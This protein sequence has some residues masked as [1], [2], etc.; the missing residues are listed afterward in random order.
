MDSQFTA[1]A[2][3]ISVAAFVVASV[4]LLYTCRGDRRKSGIDIRYR[5]AISSSVS[6]SERWVSEVVLQNAK[7]RAVSI[8]KMYLEVGHGLYIEIED[9]SRSPLILEA[10]GIHHQQ[11]DPIE[12]YVGGPYRCIDVLGDRKSRQR[13]V[14]IT[15]Q[16]RHFPKRRIKFDDPIY[17][18]IST[19]Y[20]ASVVH[21]IRL[22]YGGRSYGSEVMYIVT[23]KS[24]DGKE[25]VIPIYPRDYELKWFK[26]LGL[27]RQAME[28]K[29]ALEDCIR[30]QMDMGNLNCADV[31][32]FDP[33]PGRSRWYHEYER[34]GH[35][36]VRGWFQYNVLGRCWTMRERWRMHRDN[37][38]LRKNAEA[39]G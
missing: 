7:D 4:A 28:S 8:F 5:L 27:T 18:S 38:G 33:G 23:L 35:V 10:Y 14:L 12:F 11:Y 32:I 20:T 3:V 6:S 19:N 29:Q 17:D 25:E 37:Q 22:D 24:A 15:A 16:G 30:S 1:L 21:P 36:P 34:A 9:F 31:D 39:N 13:L 2:T 26:E